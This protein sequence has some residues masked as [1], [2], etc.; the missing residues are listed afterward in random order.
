MGFPCV[1]AAAASSRHFGCASHAPVSAGSNAADARQIH[2]FM[3][4]S[5]IQKA[6]RTLPGPRRICLAADPGVE[7]VAHADPP[8]EVDSYAL[9]H[10]QDFPG[11]IADEIDHRAH[12]AG[13]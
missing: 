4:I 10:L 13:P 12:R 6:A 8:G 11:A 3:V 2:R 5:R 9:R 1:A 7:Q